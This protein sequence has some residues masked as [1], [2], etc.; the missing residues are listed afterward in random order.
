MGEFSNFLLLISTFSVSTLYISEIVMTDEDG[1]CRFQWVCS[2]RQLGNENPFFV[3]FNKNVHNWYD[4]FTLILDFRTFVICTKGSANNRK[5]THSHIHFVWIKVQFR[6]LA[7]CVWL[8][9]YVLR[10]TT[11]YELRRRWRRQLPQ[12]KSFVWK[13]WLVCLCSPRFSVRY[14]LVSTHTYVSSHFI[15]QCWFGGCRIAACK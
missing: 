12:K 10:L 8:M 9:G 11:V 1:F 7:E 14:I 5:R 4:T 15:E 6:A 13:V 3:H 2:L